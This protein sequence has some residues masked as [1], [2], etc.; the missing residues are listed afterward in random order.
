MKTDRAMT[1]PS[2]V[3]TVSQFGDSLSRHC[4]LSMSMWVDLYAEAL[5]C[6]H[7]VC[8]QA[9]IRKK[10]QL[11]W[12]LSVPSC[13]LEPFPVVLSRRALATHTF[14]LLGF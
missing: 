11:D 9:A 10:F 2:E 4:S 1:E 3:V 13:V 8:P 6:H 5:T 12:L 14:L 7:T